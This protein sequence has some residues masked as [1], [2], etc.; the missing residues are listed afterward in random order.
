MTIPSPA[1]SPE[2]SPSEGLFAQAE[3]G[4]SGA[5]MALASLA[6]WRTVPHPAD[7]TVVRLALRTAYDRHNPDAGGSPRLYR[8]IEAIEDAWVPEAMAAVL[9]DRR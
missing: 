5:M 8:L 2:S 4:M 6:G 7:R 3:T 9:A 1:V